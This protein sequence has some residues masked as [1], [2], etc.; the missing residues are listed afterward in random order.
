MSTISLLDG[1]LVGILQG[2]L[3][4]LPLSSSGQLMVVLSRFLGLH[5]RAAY[6]LGLFLHLGTALSATIFY[7]ESLLSS[8]NGLVR[9]G[10]LDSVAKLLLVTTLFSAV[11]GVPVYIAYA[12]F[13]SGISCDTVMLPVGLALL[14]T[15]LILWLRPKGNGRRLSDAS[16][17][18]YTLLGIVQGFAVLPGLS[19]SAVTIALLCLRGF[20]PL[21]AVRGSFLAA[22]PVSVAAGLLEAHFV[23]LAPPH[24]VALASAFL[25]GVAAI[26]AVTS[27]SSRVKMAPF[28]AFLSCLMIL[29][30]VPAYLT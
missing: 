2:I 18:D 11:S 3:E 12:H 5:P 23:P 10:R 8:L 1:L 15:A 6:E 26:G 20:E 4:W 24:L 16:I 25:V 28:L 30:A 13:L 17:R 29:S 21:E 27:V 9:A 22:I 7:R 19:R 14:A